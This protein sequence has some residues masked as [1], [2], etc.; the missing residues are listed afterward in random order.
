VLEIQHRC[1]WPLLGGSDDEG[2]TF[3]QGGGELTSAASAAV[4]S[5]GIFIVDHQAL[6]CLPAEKVR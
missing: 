2:I 6:L 5:Y 1:H 3:M 4:C